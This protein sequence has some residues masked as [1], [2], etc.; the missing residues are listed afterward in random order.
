[1]K[2][3]IITYC[4]DLFCGF[5]GVTFSLSQVNNMKVIWCINHCENAIISH[6]LNHP[7][8]EHSIE[9]IRN[10]DITP[11]KALVDQ[12]RRVD[13]TC[14]IL[15]HA[16]LECL[17]FSLAKNGEKNEG[18]RTLADDLF[19]YL[20]ILDVDILTI[21]NVRQFKNWGP[22]DENN[23]IDKTRLG[24]SYNA[25]VKILTTK[26]FN[27]RFGEHSLVSADF[28]G[29]TIRDRLFLQFAKDPADIGTPKP[30]HTKEEWL[31]VRDL[32][33]TEDHGK[34][35]IHR[36]K[37]L[38]FNTMR[39]AHKGLVKYGHKAGTHFGIKYY[40]VDGWQ[41]MDDPC[42]TLTTKDRVYPVYIKMDYGNSIG[43]SLD[44]P[45]GTLTTSPKGDVVYAKRSSFIH[46]P[47]YGG[48]TRS[49]DAPCATIIASQNKAPLGLTEAFHH[50][51]D[52][53]V[54]IYSEP[55]GLHPIRKVGDV[56]EYHVYDSDNGWMKALKRHCFQHGI[57]D[58][59]MRP[60]R[61]PEM[62]QIQGLPKDY[63]MVGT[64]TEQKRWIGNA[65]EGH[66][67]IGFFGSINIAIQENKAA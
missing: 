31:S 37:A 34:S 17:E 6:S 27:K 24:E 3:E 11:L 40:G 63:K 20:D 15:L 7:E 48:S 66:V 36:P 33:D 4:I 41:D 44:S 50:N 25:W 56:V 2:K 47:Q 62:L 61:I 49:I 58:V 23:N 30:T 5:G 65:V 32:I 21:E 53:K 60:L 13:P 52:K 38:A 67:G 28:G 39:R 1:M 10:F 54:L 55:D 19:R 29:R 35:M 64:E 45:F 18:S 57:I 26:Y 9:D 16:S 46:N 22:L 59:L 51:V 12:L 8:A 14:K 43:S 42:A